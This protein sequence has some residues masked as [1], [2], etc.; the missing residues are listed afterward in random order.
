MKYEEILGI[1]FSNQSNEFVVHTNQGSD[2]H[3]ISPDKITIV[4][5]IA[6][7]Y[8]KTLKKAIILCE[9]NEKSL[10]QYVTTKKDK[11]KRYK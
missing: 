7:F 9:I 3:F 6:K 4:Y 2:F 8:E 11:K 10:K 1:T 5:I